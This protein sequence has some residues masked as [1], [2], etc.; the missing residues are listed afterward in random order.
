MLEK[1]DVFLTTVERAKIAEFQL[2][3]DVFNNE[4]SLYEHETDMLTGGK[5]KKI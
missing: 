5:P 3:T 1:N 2:F 4:K